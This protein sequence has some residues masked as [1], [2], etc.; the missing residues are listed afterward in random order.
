MFNIEKS[1][2]CL[3]K[4]CKQWEFLIIYCM[5]RISSN[6]L[7]VNRVNTIYL[8]PLRKLTIRS[9]HPATQAWR[10][11]LHNAVKMLFSNGHVATHVE[12]ESN[13]TLNLIIWKVLISDGI[14]M[15]N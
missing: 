8:M 1:K 15:Y 4:L 13:E 10:R 11:V 12:N 14:L 2:L 6:P 3:L 9:P 7:T 5:W